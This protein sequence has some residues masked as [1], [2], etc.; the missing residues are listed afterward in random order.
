MQMSHWCL[1]EMG[2]R[3]GICGPT[4]NPLQVHP[5]QHPMTIKCSACLGDWESVEFFELACQ[6]PNWH[7][8][9]VICLKDAL[10]WTGRACNIF[11][12]PKL[13]SCLGAII[14][15]YC[16]D[17]RPSQFCMW[18]MPKLF[19]PTL[20]NSSSSEDLRTDPQPTASAPTTTSQD[21]KML[22]LPWRLRISWFCW[23][24]MPTSE[25]A[26]VVGH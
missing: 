6:H 7:V 21:Y 14:Q 9:W 20:W 5:Q 24:G 3:P 4:H 1:Y 15:W 18:V 10:F 23:T 11:F 2:A 16:W 26:C 8:L 12:H 13:F 25:L 19:C 17:F 22:S